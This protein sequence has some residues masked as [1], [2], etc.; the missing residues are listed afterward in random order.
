MGLQVAD[1]C[2]SSVPLREP[3]RK[4]EARNPT[5]FSSLL[6]YFFLATKVGVN[7]LSVATKKL[8]SINR[9]PPLGTH[10]NP[11]KKRK[12]GREC[13]KKIIPMS[14]CFAEKA[15]RIAMQPHFAKKKKKIFGI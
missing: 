4:Q 12:T 2:T 13:E 9:Y 15:D 5:S 11:K 3:R 6:L 8:T 7:R 14:A 1:W 10:N